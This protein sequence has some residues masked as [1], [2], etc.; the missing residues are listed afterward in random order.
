[1][2]QF[3]AHLDRGWELVQKGDTRGAAASARRALELDPNSPEAHNLL[4]YV[5]A[6]E[7]EG[8]EAIEAYQQAI[9]LDDTYLEAMLNAAEVYISPLGDFDQAIRMC[10][11]ALDLAEVDEE[12][13]DALLLKFDALMGKGEREEA[14]KV[15]NQVPEGP[16][17]N[18]THLFLVGR[19]LY[20]MGDIDKARRLVEDAAD[21]DPR[22]PEAHY[23]LGLIKDELG[24]G[25]GA[26]VAFLRAREL[27]LTQGMP[28]WSPPR[29]EWERCAANAF[30][31]LNPLLHK[32]VGGAD[33]FISDLP[34][35]ELVAEGVD[36]RALIILDGF[37]DDGSQEDIARVMRQ[38]VR[39]ARVFI[40]AINVARQAGQLS[41]IEAEI[42]AALE[43][44]IS[45]TFLEP[46]Q[47]ERNV[48][49]MN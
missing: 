47:Q 8:E 13:I 30:G 43:R 45:A 34:G 6:M 38:P 4:G 27:D 46:G 49:E 40:Y 3:S 18:P 44:E 25:K 42:L 32:Y 29:E 26:T 10:D 15:L 41:A 16:Y 39:A 33:V 7:G 48:K 5:A 11:Q 23:Y 31:M 20:E 9:A 14:K 1:M 37:D 21:K 35:V 2:D 17:E 28:P 22:H 19:A 12:V 36:P 24:D